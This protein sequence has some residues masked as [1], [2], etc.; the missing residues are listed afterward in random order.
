MNFT[1]ELIKE[2][3]GKNQKKE[4][5][6]K[7]HNFIKPKENTERKQDKISKDSTLVVFS[8]PIIK[9]IDLS[10]HYDF[11]LETDGPLVIN[12]IH[13]KSRDGKTVVTIR[14]DSKLELSSRDRVYL[15][16]GKRKYEST[17]VY[18][19]RCFVNYTLANK[20]NSEVYTQTMFSEEKFSANIGT[21]KT[22]Q[23]GIFYINLVYKTEEV[24]SILVE[25]LPQK[26][27]QFLIQKQKN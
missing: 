9:V 20:S 18:N 26:T 14:I 6:P 22:M 19:A 8:I 4:N 12:Y 5:S 15:N 21:N 16:R 7:D 27:I 24:D 17:P 23:N 25:I 10:R 3:T 11:S 1:K 2:L 13:P